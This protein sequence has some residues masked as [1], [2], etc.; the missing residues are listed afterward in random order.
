MLDDLLCYSAFGFVFLGRS[1]FPVCR[2]P[3]HTQ[4]IWDPLVRERGCFRMQVCASPLIIEGVEM[5]NSAAD[6]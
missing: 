5:S 4:L 1:S 6:V 3:P 2:C